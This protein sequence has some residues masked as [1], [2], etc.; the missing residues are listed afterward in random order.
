MISHARRPFDGP[1]PVCKQ[2]R[3]LAIVVRLKLGIHDISLQT[4]VS[5]RP[6]KVHC[7]WTLKQAQSEVEA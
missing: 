6:S 7:H 3:G 2:Q 5:G 4:R 1:V